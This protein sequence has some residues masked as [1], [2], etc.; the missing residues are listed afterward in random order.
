MNLFRLPK[1]LFV[2]TSLTLAFGVIIYTALS[3]ALVL[4]FI[5]LPMANRAAEDMASFITMASESW[6]RLNEQERVKFQAHLRDQHQ[7]FITADPVQVAEINQYYPFIPLLEKAL[8][9]H[10]GQ[11]VAIKQDLNNSYCFWVDL[12]QGEQKISI[13]FFHKRFGP[14][15]PMA[16]AG[17]LAT[18]CFLIVIASMLLVRRITNH[19]KRL[20]IAANHFGMGDFSTRIPETGPEELAS[21]A[22]S[23]NRM[24]QE[25]TQLMSNRTILFG[26]ISHDLRTPITRMQIALELLEEDENSPLMAGL[27]NDLTEMEQLIQQ[28]L[29]LVKGL[30]KHPPVETDLEQLLAKIVKDYQRQHHVILR[31]KRICG[32]HKIEADVLRRVL[33][34]LLDNSFRYGGNKPVKLSCLKIKKNLVIRINDEGPGIPKDKI[35]SVFQPFFRLDHSRS[36][37]TGGSG[38]G[39]AIVRQLCDVHGWKIQLFPGKRKGME[40]CLIIPLSD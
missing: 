13:G 11:Q 17:I 7:L 40:A 27:K 32:T 4:Y 39:L 37:K 23:F 33:T 29:E 9:R 8:F 2:N 3:I 36:K 20:S 21:L 31:E 25:L 19:I 5:L 6:E 24:A 12:Q 35:E 38:L 10:A 34:N 15:P 16:L 28:A 14:R 1:S 18:G 26:G 22:Q 30:D